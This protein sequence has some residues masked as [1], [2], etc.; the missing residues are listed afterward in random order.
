MNLDSI[1]LDEK[2]ILL[3]AKQVAETGWD[4]TNLPLNNRRSSKGIQCC[5]DL[6]QVTAC[7]ETLEG[8]P[9]RSMFAKH[10]RRGILTTGGG[11]LETAEAG[12]LECMEANMP[13]QETAIC[14]NGQN[15]AKPQAATIARETPNLSRQMFPGT[16]NMSYL[17]LGLVA[18]LFASRTVGILILASIIITMVI[19]TK[20]PKA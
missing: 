1:E 8:A 3:K 14:R 10:R 12:E 15:D 17:T 13:R 5:I 11:L 20:P 18:G 9:H 2:I 6:E 7:A 16:A 4:T 19:V